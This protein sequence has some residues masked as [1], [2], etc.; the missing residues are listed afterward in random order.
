VR[1]PRLRGRSLQ[2]EI[3]FQ[4]PSGAREEEEMLQETPRLRSVSA[5]CKSASERGEI[6]QRVAVVE[7]SRVQ[8]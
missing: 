6:L 2:Q 8:Q 4:D 7:V 3:N 5:G 1:S